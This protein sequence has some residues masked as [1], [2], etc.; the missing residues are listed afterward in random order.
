M[1]LV[2]RYLR[3]N[4]HRVQQLVCNGPFSLCDRDAESGWTRDLHSCQR[5]M[6]E[7]AAI[8][9][10]C[11]AEKVELSGCLSGDDIEDTRR[12]MLRLDAGEL[13][14]AQFHG[15]KLFELCRETLASRFGVRDF[16]PANRSHEQFARRVMLSAMRMCLATARFNNQ[17]VPFLTLVAGGEDYITRSFLSESAVQRR[18]A[19]VFRWEASARSIRVFHPRKSEVF[20]CEFILQDITAMRSDVATWP[21]ELTGAA[22]DLVNFLGIQEKAEALAAAQ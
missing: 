9:G 7:Q 13:A 8:A 4:G 12:W 14:Q 15:R 2:A 22:G 11:G 16:D 5:C 21:A 6:F 19:A 18:S 20:S 17:H 10:W 3:S 1:G